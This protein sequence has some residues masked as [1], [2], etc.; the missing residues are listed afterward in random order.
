MKM[1][2]AIVSFGRNESFPLRFGWIAKG[3]N[4]LDDDPRVFN[5][6]DATVILGVGKNM[7]ASIRYWLQATGVA[8]R[9]RKTNALEPTPLG[10]IAFGDDGDPYLEDEGT[11]WLLHWLLA[12]NSV[13]ATAIYWFFNHFHKPRFSGAEV[14]TALT[15][16]VKRE[17]SSKVA[18][19]T[20]KRDAQLMLRMYSR[21]MG[22]T[23]L[24]LEDALD[25]PLAMLNLQQRLDGRNWRAIPTNRAEIPLNVFA[26][27]VAQLFGATNAAQLAIRDLMY[28]GANHCAPG[29]VFRMTE[30][31]LI[32]KL[33]A[34][35]DAYPRVLRLDRTAGVFQLYKLGTLEALSV[36]EDRYSASGGKLA[37]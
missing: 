27:A 1:N 9:N 31:G 14:A 4:A 25:S 15:D 18:V 21:T 26:F 23:R 6:E 28:S 30:E 20:L 3:L 35:C 13:H 10:Q 8:V 11:I 36:L 37:A 22:G 32:R 16:F 2:S 17:I 33:E 34:L 7:V 29:A 19:T 12:T 24:T 5:R